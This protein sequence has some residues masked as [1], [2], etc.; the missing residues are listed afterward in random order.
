[1]LSRRATFMLAFIASMTAAASSTVEAQQD[2]T[3]TRDSAVIWRPLPVLDD[4]GRE[5]PESLIVSTMRPGT[6]RMRRVVT[7]A[8][9]GGILFAA[10]NT[11]GHDCDIY[12]P[13]T[14]REKFRE[15]FG[16]VTGLFVGGFL[17]VASASPGIDREQAV[18]LIRDQR[19]AEERRT[20]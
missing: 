17:G 14:Q 12:D 3:I 18:K 2:T 15:S 20:P 4:S 16:W 19:R 9:L 13:C 11:S 6:V 7:T 8:L 5:I 10:L 1:M